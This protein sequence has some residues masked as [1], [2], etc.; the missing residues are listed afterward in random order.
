MLPIQ[1]YY[2]V[3][4]EKIQKPKNY[5]DCMTE[6]INN[7]FSLCIDLADDYEARRKKHDHDKQEQP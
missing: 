3:N 2:I 7:Y 5:N 1:L 6:V 4:L